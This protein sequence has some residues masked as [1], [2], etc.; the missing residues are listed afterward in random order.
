MATLIAVILGIFVALVLIYIFFKM[1]KYVFF[2]LFFVFSLIPIICS[3]ILYG[4][5]KIL[6]IDG[7]VYYLLGL[8]SVPSLLYL[9]LVH[10][11]YTKK[12]KIIGK[13]EGFAKTRKERQI[14]IGML[15]FYN[16]LAAGFIY[17][18]AYAPTDMYKT[19]FLIL[20]CAYAIFSF[21]YACYKNFMW[22]HDYF[23]FYQR[24]MEWHQ[25]E[26][27]ECKP[28]L[29]IELEKKINSLSMEICSIDKNRNKFAFEDIPY[30]RVIAFISYFNR[31][32][33]NE[34]PV[35]F[36]PRMSKNEEELR[37]YGTLITTRGIYIS[38]PEK[39]DVELPFAGLYKVGK[40]NDLY[41][42]EYGLSYGEEKRHFVSC[43]DVSINFDILNK[44]KNYEEVPLTMLRRKEKQEESLESYIKSS[45]E[46]AQKD[47][48]KSQEFKNVQKSAELGGLASGVSQD[49]HIINDEVK[50][51]M[52]GA[53][54]GGYAAEYGNNAYDRF[55]GKDV[56]NMA[57]DLDNGHQK[58]HGADRNVNG[59][60]IQTKYYMSASE[61]I[62]AAFEKGQAL[63]LNEDGSM[64]QI[65]VP[66]DQYNQAVLEMQK[67]IQKGQVPGENNPNHASKYVRKGLFTY[68]Q[69]NSIA[70]AGTV[71]SLTV[72]AMQGISCSLPG[73]GITAAITF[74][75]AIWNGQN[76]E[77]AAKACA[78]SSL[79]TI[80]KNAAIYVLTMQLSRD[81]VTDVLGISKDFDE[82]V[83]KIYGPVSKNQLVSVADKVAAEIKATSIAKSQIGNL[84]GLDKVTGRAIIGG[85]V[86]AAITFG[87]DI[88]R[89]LQGKISG[90]QLLKNSA[91]T[92]AGMAA[93]GVVGTLI[94]IPYVG[95]MLG[96]S[97]GGYIAKKA[98]DTF[99]DDDAV[100]MFRILREEF[101]DIVMQ[102]SLHKDEFDYVINETLVKVE[103][104]QILQNMFQ[105]GTPKEYAD[106]FISRVVCEVLAKRP[107]VT[108]SM[109]E[110]GMEQ[111]L[112]GKEAA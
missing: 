95:T 27:K 49:A 93:G 2:A 77:D 28:I 65:E 98:L 92:A 25:W 83:I 86:T 46:K 26:S 14:T 90:Q 112:N 23:D 33:E 50:S 78:T 89:A 58:L 37:E 35:Y 80:G 17:L 31:T 53:R 34:E 47:F 79:R 85:S 1:L 69:A 4:V 71:E 84:L 109:M 42:F 22:S 30:G 61:S 107:K 56:K 45:M 91:V 97:A 101:L 72:D 48:D 82:K 103:E 32:L 6:H 75:S 38:Q 54:G 108:L 16:L 102:N 51:Y 55:S 9:C 21:F 106:E 111:M 63:Y 44:S 74:A 67:R 12:E 40:K 39:N 87:P 20:G 24:C 76:L 94:P 52:N 88:C 8:C 10:I 104:K 68:A 73:A 36:S 13:K 43:K 7:F 66:R 62:G 41:E 64:M 60:N 3:R 11:P 5:T 110:E 100:V 19:K 15:L 99:V 59:M 81:K 70:V 29:E 18:Y 96:A 105:T 57:Q